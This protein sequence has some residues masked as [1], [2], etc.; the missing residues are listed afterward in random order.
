MRKVANPV[1]LAATTS[2]SAVA[3]AFARLSAVT[4]QQGAKV[5]SAAVRNLVTE[6]VENWNGDDPGMSRHWVEDAVSRLTEPDQA[7]GRLTL[8]TALASYQVDEQVIDEYRQHFPSDGQL[9]AA[10]SWASFAA[11]RRISSWLYADS[12][13]EAQHHKRVA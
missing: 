7:A 9:I 1:S 5:L 2:N 13:S 10:T 11:T 6:R 4:E 3:G 8:L 12:R